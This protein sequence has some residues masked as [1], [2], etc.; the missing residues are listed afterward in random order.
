MTLQPKITAENS[1]L[2]LLEEKNKALFFRCT[3]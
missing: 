1:E 2:H 3:S